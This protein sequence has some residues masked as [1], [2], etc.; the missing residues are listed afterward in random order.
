MTIAFTER[1]YS[2]NVS[3]KLAIA[4]SAAVVLLAGCG[5]G[6]HDRPSPPPTKAG[7][8]AAADRVCRETKTH[9]ARIAG[10]RKLRPPADERDLYERW[11]SAER[12]AVGAA[13]VIEGRKQQ[14]EKMDPLVQLAIARGKIAGYAG[15]LGARACRVAPGVTMSS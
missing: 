6:S 7:F 10:L 5:G 2:R 4:G 1:S 12:L 14:Q 13:D 9:R 15:R 3:R 11:L 8:A